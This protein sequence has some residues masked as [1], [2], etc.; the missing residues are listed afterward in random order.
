MNELHNDTQAIAARLKQFVRA[1]AP[2]HCRAV[3]LGA[4]CPCPLC[5]IDRW[6]AHVETLTQQVAELTEH[7]ALKTAFTAGYHS[8]WTPQGWLFIPA[9]RPGDAAGAYAAWLAIADAAL[10][11]SALPEG[12]R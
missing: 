10:A 4:D 11:A 12:R 1:M 2:G 5:D 9:L 7:A 8:T 6:S 3:S